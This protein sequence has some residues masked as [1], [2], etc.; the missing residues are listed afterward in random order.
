[1]AEV[2]PQVTEESPKKKKKLCG[3]FKK[4]DPNIPIVT[5]RIKLNPSAV[6]KQKLLRTMEEF[7]KGCN[8]MSEIVFAEWT[9]RKRDFEDI[10]EAK[11]QAKK[12]KVKYVPDGKEVTPSPF[13]FQRMKTIA[14]YPVYHE[15][16]LHSQLVSEMVA[17]VLY[18][19]KIDKKTQREY[20]PHGAIGYN[21]CD[22]TIEHNEEIG[23]H[24]KLATAF[25]PEKIPIILNNYNGYDLKRRRGGVKISYTNGKFFLLVPIEKD[26][27]TRVKAVDWKGDWLG[28][29]MGVVNITAD[30]FGE[31]YSGGHINGIRSRHAK[32]RARLQAKG[33]RSA[34][35]LMKA[36]RYKESRFRNN[37]NHIIAKAIVKK[38]KENDCA[39]ALEDLTGIR[40]TT[41]VRKKQ[42][43]QHNSWSFFDLRLKIEYKA[44]LANVVVGYVDP[45]Y[46]SQTCSE[47]GHISK[48]N[49][50][51]QSEFACQDCG[52]M[53]N[54]DLNAALNIQN[55]ARKGLLI[56]PDV[57]KKKRDATDKK[58]MKAK[59]EEKEREEEEKEQRMADR[60]AGI[61]PKPKRKKART[62]PVRRRK[63][64]KNKTPD[65]KRGFSK[66]NKKRKKVATGR[67][68]TSKSDLAKSPLAAKGGR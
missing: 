16:G 15:T 20:S 49:R 38:A 35:R 2:Q 63:K 62:R 25:G 41:V 34:K 50:K 67:T 55:R 43:R 33:T 19:Y 52:F 51:S 53:C 9:R 23:D 44:A 24:I 13:S 45:R 59:A 64:R 6:Q 57:E 10:K 36:R 68:L 14:Y 37:Q 11:A 61:K 7:N 46:T 65:R 18:S 27:P 4:K 56:D 32:T 58:E 48:K 31:S 60:K 21:R 54:A 42:R 22:L 47:C 39:I 5:Y 17:K 29:D 8:F 12:D 30:N 66:N 3:I 26:K 40:Q 28:I 1:M